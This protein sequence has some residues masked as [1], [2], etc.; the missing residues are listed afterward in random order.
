MNNLFYSFFDRFALMLALHLPNKHLITADLIE[1]VN[2]SCKMVVM[3]FVSLFTAFTV[4]LYNLGP[5]LFKLLL[6]GRAKYS[7]FRLEGAWLTRSKISITLTRR[8][9]ML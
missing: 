3:Y 2:L 9:L 5:T 6:Y 8:V 4:S 1:F 7:G